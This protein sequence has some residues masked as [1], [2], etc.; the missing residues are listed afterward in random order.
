MRSLRIAGVAAA[1]IASLPLATPALADPVTGTGVIT[2]VITHA[3][4]TPSSSMVTV[5][6]LDDSFTETNPTSDADGRYTF[7]DVPAGQYQISYY[8]NIHIDQWIHGAVDR[9]QA[10]T[11]TLAEGATVEADD[12]W[13]PGGTVRVTLGDSLTG[14]P[15]PKPC[16]TVRSTPN[17][18]RAC[19]KNGVVVIKDVPPGDWEIDLS[20]GASYFPPA[21]QRSVTVK[22]G[23][24]AKVIATLEPG[25]AIRTRAVDAATGAPVTNI[26]VDVV[27]TSFAGQNF[28]SPQN[29]SGD[30]GVIEIG[31]LGYTGTV[32]L[33]AGQYVGPFD[34]DPTVHYGDQWAG[35]RGGT[36]DQ[37]KART[38]TLQE[39]VTTTVP[40]IRM[41]PA[42]AISGTITT[43][44]TGQPAGGIC[45]FPYATYSAHSGLGPNCS[46]SQGHYVIDGL[47][48]YNWPVEFAPSLNKGLAWQWSGG[49][50]DRF[51]ATYS[52]VRAAQTTTV[53]AAL[54]PGGTLTGT[55]TEGGV[56]ATSVQVDAFN[57]K[58]HDYAGPT[59]A[60][61]DNAGN[62]TL[63]GFRTQSLWV[64]YNAYSEG[65][66]CWAPAAVTDGQTTHVAADLTTECGTEPAA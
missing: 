59:Y 51:A 27:D 30:D 52:A 34:P 44:A 40:A 31:P 33:Y 16:A 5:H 22:R 49:K 65:R 61:L 45:A 1:V 35:A 36:G 7:D 12:R 24:T 47:G 43:A 13:L 8:D 39:H 3:D 18:V 29:C 41:D 66:Q 17:E 38:V 19:G 46:D 28:L 57:Q 25:T 54:V 23:R 58:T 42:G 4:G 6:S 62:F 26:C 56:P 48:P 60:Y 14:K 9:S 53:D 15:V 64:R 32:N 50:A 2:G 21:D 10:Q 55:V 11:F 37:R 20:G 63:P